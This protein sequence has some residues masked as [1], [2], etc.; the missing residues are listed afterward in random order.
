[1]T[2]HT[3]AQTLPPGAGKSS[4]ELVDVS[5]LFVELDLNKGFVF[6]DFGCGYGK[7][8]MAAAEAVGETG[9]VYAVDLWEEG[10]RELSARSATYTNIRTMIADIGDRVPLP[11]GSVD[12]CF[13]ATVLHDLVLTGRGDRAVEE[14]ARTLK[15]HGILAIVEFKKIPGPPG[16][17]VGIRLDPDEVAAIVSPKGFVKNRSV[18]I[19]PYHYLMVFA[20]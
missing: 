14:A 18:D 15:D 17:P 13:M 12:V 19:G 10:I 11:D 4:F 9:L 1:M 7:Y 3:E 20:R 5:K 2:K 16:P 6:A 8:S